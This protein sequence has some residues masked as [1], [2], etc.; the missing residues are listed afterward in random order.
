MFLE[1]KAE[2][3]HKIFKILITKHKHLSKHK[4]NHI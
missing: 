1:I 2:I 4:F 3:Y